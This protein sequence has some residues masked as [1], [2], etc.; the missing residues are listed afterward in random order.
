MTE[1]E[2][3]RRETGM[4]LL[5]KVCCACNWLLL[6]FYLLRFR[7]AILMPVCPWLGYVTS[8]I[9]EQSSWWASCCWVP[10]S[11]ASLLL[12]ANVFCV[13]AFRKSPLLGSFFW[14]CFVTFPGC[15]LLSAPTSQSIAAAVSLGTQRRDNSCYSFQYWGVN[16]PL[17]SKHCHKQDKR[18]V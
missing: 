12:Q 17:G 18:A 9:A 11:R 4:S 7:M 14:G 6:Q 16:A 10:V 2:M 5:Y 8:Q 3:W 13:D 15:G 1:P